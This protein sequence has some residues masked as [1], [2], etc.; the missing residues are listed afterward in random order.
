M[1]S[2]SRFYTVAQIADMLAVSPRT[3]RRWIA[4]GELLAHKFRRQVR[5]SEI[6]LRTFLALSKL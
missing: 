2:L 5:I 3:V 4:A 1:S 6:D